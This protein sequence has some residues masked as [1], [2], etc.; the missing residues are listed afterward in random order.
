MLEEGH[1]WAKKEVTLPVSS[2][3]YLLEDTVYLKLSKEEVAALQA[4]P[5]KW[6]A[7]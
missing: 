5:V 6:H 3:D 2:V 7:R 1:F 4:V